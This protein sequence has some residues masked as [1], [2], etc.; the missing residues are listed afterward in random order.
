MTI[1][2]RISYALLTV[3]LILAWISVS[4]ASVDWSIRKEIPVKDKAKDVAASANGKYIY[5]LTEDNRILIYT[6]TGVFQD[7]INTGSQIGSIAAGPREDMLFLYNAGSSAVEILRIDF[8]KKINT[9][10]SPYLGN[11]EATVIVA[12][13]TDYQ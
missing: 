5:V 7:E 12:V 9:T 4:F 2:N 13:F 3:F 10:G 8:L 11:P 6:V 1:K